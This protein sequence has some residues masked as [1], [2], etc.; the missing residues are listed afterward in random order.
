MMIFV[1]TSGSQSDRY[2]SLGDAENIL[3]VEKFGGVLN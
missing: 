3:G 2:R 1:Y